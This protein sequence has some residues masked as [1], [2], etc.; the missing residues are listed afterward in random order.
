VLDSV[1]KEPRY[2]IPDQEGRATG[3]TDNLPQEHVGE[4]ADV[5]L[6]PERLGHRRE[7]IDDQADDA[8]LVDV[9]DDFLPNRGQSLRTERG[10]LEEP[11][12]VL[13]LEWRE[14]QAKA[15]HVAEIR[16]APLPHGD[17]HPGLAPIPGAL[18]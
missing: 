14:V 16:L 3:P 6:S 10:H 4:H 12:Q 9:P 18:V 1:P 11:E 8:G 5:A 15:G 7:R 17:V 13:F 2:P